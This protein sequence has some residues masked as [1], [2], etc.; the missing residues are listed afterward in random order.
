MD[1]RMD[2]MC[3]K[4]MKRKKGKGDLLSEVGL[5]C[6]F[7]LVLFSPRGDLKAELFAFA[8][9]HPTKLQICICTRPSKGRRVLS[10][11]LCDATVVE[12]GRA[13][14][15]CRFT[16]IPSLRANDY[17]GASFLSGLCLPTPPPDGSGPGLPPKSEYIHHVEP[18]C[19]QGIL[20]TFVSMFGSL[21]GS[22]MAS[23]WPHE[24]APSHHSR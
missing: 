24:G 17:G 22:P 14:M 10:M 16:F 2:W 1:G 3:G 4:W 6:F 18:C 11:V 8:L 19:V 5:W 23:S 15:A 21:F 20:S 7:L 12:T 13:A 9:I